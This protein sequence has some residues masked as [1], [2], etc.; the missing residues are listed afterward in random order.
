MKGETMSHTKEHI[1]HTTIL[2]LNDQFGGAIQMALN[3]QN[4]VK[5]KNRLKLRTVSGVK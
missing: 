3:W 1:R 5:I 2:A 4:L